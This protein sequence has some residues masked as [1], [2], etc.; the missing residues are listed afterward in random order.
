MVMMQMRW[1]KALFVLCLVALAASIWADAN[2]RSIGTFCFGALFLLCIY[3]SS[4]QMALSNKL[5]LWVGSIS[6]S[7]YV[8]HLA[9]V[10]VV[11]EVA[12]RSIENRTVLSE[13]AIV[14]IGVLA[15]VC[16]SWLLFMSVETSSIRWSKAVVW[17]RR[18]EAAPSSRAVIASPTRGN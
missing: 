8:I 14:S 18:H 10:Y 13:L 11:Y 7:M 3:S 5:L 1:G 4:F 6:Y 16:F 9:V 2:R 17:G 15:T 12:A